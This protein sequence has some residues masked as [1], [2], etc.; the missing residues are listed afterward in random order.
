MDRLKTLDLP[1]LA[2]LQ[3]YLDDPSII[4]KARIT[5]PTR[6]SSSSVIKLVEPKCHADSNLSK[7]LYHQMHTRLERC[8]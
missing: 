3:E 4:P 8:C 2:L 1:P 5:R 6:S 7:V